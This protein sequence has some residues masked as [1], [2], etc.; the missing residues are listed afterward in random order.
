MEMRRFEIDLPSYEINVMK[1][2][3]HSLNHRIV[4]LVLEAGESKKALLRCLG[5]YP[6]P[7]GKLNLHQQVL[8]RIVTPKNDII[9]LADIH[10]LKPACVRD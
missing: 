3:E 10:Q 8:A 6:N 9:D 5:F 7:C 2:L 1:I 4:E